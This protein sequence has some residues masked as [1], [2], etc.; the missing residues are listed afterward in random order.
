MPRKIKVKKTLTPKP[1][2]SRVERN[3]FV[4]SKLS[5]FPILTDPP[6]TAA[7]INGVTN[8]VTTLFGQHVNGD[9]DATIKMYVQVKIMDGYYYDMAEYVEQVSNL[10]DDASLPVSLGMELYAE[11][12]ARKPKT[13]GI[14]DG[15]HAGEIYFEYP[16]IDNAA[17]YSIQVAE[18]IDDTE[19]VFVHENSCSIT[20]FTITGKKSNTRYKFRVAGIFSDGEG[21]WSEP[22]PFRTKDWQ[23]NNQ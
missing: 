9:K 2:I 8:K 12:E 22:V 6:H 7:E 18:V 10:Q 5:S 14:W 23:F 4:A 16:V 13:F 20:S 15:D 19:P 17:A 1:I 3:E 21:S 11:K